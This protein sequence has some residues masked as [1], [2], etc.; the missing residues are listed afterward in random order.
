MRATHICMTMMMVTCLT[1][2]TIIYFRIA[3]YYMCYHGHQYLQFLSLFH[4]YCLGIFYSII[5]FVLFDY[6]ITWWLLCCKAQENYV[7][8][9][10]LI[11]YKTPRGDIEWSWGEPYKTRRLGFKTLH[12]HSWGYWTW[13]ISSSLSEVH[14]QKLLAEGICNPRLAETVS[15][16]LVSIKKDCMIRSLVCWPC[17]HNTLN[18]LS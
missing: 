9:N 3:L 17:L 7:K 2:G 5:H 4:H 13:G 14:L 11:V 12:S 18:K 16:Y 1:T 8:C 15:G 6:Q 10:V